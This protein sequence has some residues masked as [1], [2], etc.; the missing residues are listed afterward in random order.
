MPEKNVFGKKMHLVSNL[1]I[2]FYFVGANVKTLLHS[3]L[4]DEDKLFVVLKYQVSV[5]VALLS[6]YHVSILLAYLPF[7]LHLCS[8]FFVCKYLYLILAMLS[9]ILVTLSLK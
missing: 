3:K 6:T 7:L 9:L 2:N 1:S 4:S 5:T 8:L